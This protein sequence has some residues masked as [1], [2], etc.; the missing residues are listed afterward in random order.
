[1][2]KDLENALEK[3]AKRDDVPTATEATRLIRMAMEIDEDIVFDD[4]AKKRDTKNAKFITHNNA[5]L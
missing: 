1:M 4:L 5:W 2:P 3:L